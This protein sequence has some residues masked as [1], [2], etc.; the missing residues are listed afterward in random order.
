MMSTKSKIVLLLLVASGF[1]AF[2]TAGTAR[3]GSRVGNVQEVRAGKASKGN[4]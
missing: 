3:A 2:E 1:A 4:G